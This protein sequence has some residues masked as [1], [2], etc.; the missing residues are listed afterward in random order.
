MTF[1]DFLF[2]LLFGEFSYSF[3]ENVFH[4]ENKS[5]LEDGVD[6]CLYL[7]VVVFS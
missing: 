2:A 7:S 4:I 5:F 6:I 3:E 1:F